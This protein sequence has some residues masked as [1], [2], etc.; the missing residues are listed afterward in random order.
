MQTM[1]TSFFVHPVAS[2]EA[3]EAACQVRAL[4]YGRHVPSLRE[5]FSAPDLLDEGGGCTSF[6]A[7]DKASHAPLGTLRVQT[8]HREQPLLLEA[9]FELSEGLA[10]QTRAELTRLSVLPKADPLVRLLLWKAGLYFCLANQVQCMVIGAR[11][12][13]LI[14]QYKSLGFTELTTA[15]VIFGHAGG[16]PH[17]VLHLDVRMLER[18]WHACNHVMHRFMFDTHHPDLDVIGTR[19]RP[20][21]A[22]LDLA[23]DRADRAVSGGQL[24]QASMAQEATFAGVISVPSQRV[25][26][27]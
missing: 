16:M 3:L 18:R 6:I 27:A 9:S 14:R 26:V 2:H 19:W 23:A 17:H 21:P 13:A 8:G 11:L 20:K 4:S 15:P 22:L 1:S 7:V 5:R 10:A 25:S 24:A 12:P